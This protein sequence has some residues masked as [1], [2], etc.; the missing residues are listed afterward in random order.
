MTYK[1]VFL[2][3][4]FFICCLL[5][6]WL[7]V[8]SYYFISLTLVHVHLNCY[9]DGLHSFS[10]IFLVIRRMSKPGASFLILLVSEIFFLE[11]AL[12][13]PMSKLASSL[14]IIGTFFGWIFSRQLSYIFF[15]L[16]LFF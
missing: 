13:R 5:N 9:S 3:L 15:I 16:F 10:V 14:E 12:L 1:Y 6:F 2:E 7:I 8:K 11:K 4:L